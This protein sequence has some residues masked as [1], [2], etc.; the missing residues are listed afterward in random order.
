MTTSQTSRALQPKTNRQPTS[1]NVRYVSFLR[2]KRLDICSIFQNPHECGRFPTFVLGLISRRK[3]SWFSPRPGGFDDPKRR[4]L[5]R[6]LVTLSVAHRER[7]CNPDDSIKAH[8]F[9]AVIRKR[10]VKCRD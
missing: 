4:L 10:A 1:D 7:F 8:Q 3:T 5:R 2:Q 6:F 9:S